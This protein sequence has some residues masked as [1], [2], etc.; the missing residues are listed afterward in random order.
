LRSLGPSLM[1]NS[2]YLVSSAPLPIIAP[3]KQDN[4]SNPR[5]TFVLP[6]EKSNFSNDILEMFQIECTVLDTKTIQLVRRGY[7]QFVEQE[8]EDTRIEIE[9]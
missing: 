6:S 1:N 2:Y 7:N 4:T 3:I 5:I 9:V 8:D